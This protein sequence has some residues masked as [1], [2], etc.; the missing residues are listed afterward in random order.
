MADEGSEN[1]GGRYCAA[2]GPNMMSCKNSQFTKN[3]SLHKFPSEVREPDRRDKRTKFVRRHRPGW[4]PSKQSHLCSVHFEE[5]CY[6]RKMSLSTDSNLPKFRNYL[7]T[8]A[9]P[10]RDMVVPYKSPDS[11]RKRRKVSRSSLHAFGLLFSRDMSWCI[12]FSC[13]T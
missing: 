11:K 9:V 8:T 3:V 6:E 12:L 1:K 5:S 4:N 7:L 2:R 10:T 13:L